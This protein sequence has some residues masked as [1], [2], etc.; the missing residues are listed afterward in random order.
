MEIFVLLGLFALV[1]SLMPWINHVRLLSARDEINGLRNKIKLL[2]KRVADSTASEVGIEPKTDSVPIKEDPVKPEA[3]KEKPP[4]KRKASVPLVSNNDWVKTAQESFEKNVATKLPVWIGAISLICA[5]FFLVKYSIELGWMKPEVRLSLGGLF[6]VFLIV[7]GHW[8]LKRPHIA[9]C[10]RIS[11]GLVGAGLVALYVTIYASLSLYNL[12]PPLFGFLAMATVTGFAVILSLRHGQPIAV[13][14]LLGGLLTP[15]LVGSDE[16]NAIAMFAYLFLLFTGMF[17]VLVRKGWWLLAVAAIIGVFAWSVFWFM[18][19]FSA[20]DAVILVVF[21]IAI[22]AVVLVV[23]GRRVA[24]N[25]IEK[26]QKLPIHS[27]NFAAIIGGVITIA[28]L[29]FEVSLTLFD[30]SMLG[31]LSLALMV[32]AYF[33]PHVYQK[34]IWAKLGASI[35]LYFIWVQ[36]APLADAITVLI[37]MA[38]VYVG[39]SYFL[40]RQVSDPRFWAT[41][42]TVTAIALYLVA[43]T[44]FDLP[45][46]FLESFSMF[47]GAV[48]LLLAGLAIYQ[49]A[50]IRQKYEADATIK[51]HLLA[52]YTLA[53]SA[54]ISI[55]LAIELPWGYV[56]LAIAAQTA[57][58]AMIYNRTGIDFLKQICIILTLVFAALNYEQLIMFLE[59]FSISVEEMGGSLKR[60]SY[61]VL[62]TPLIK[63]GI[64]SLLFV[65][66]FWVFSKHKEQNKALNHILFGASL[67]FIAMTF[68]YLF[69]YVSYGDYATALTTNASFIERGVLTVIAGVAGFGLLAG[70]KK[71][72]F[73][74]L[75][76]WAFG[77]LIM[78]GA[79][80]VYFDLLIHN[81]YWDDSQRVGAMPLLNGVTLTYGGAVLLSMWAVYSKDLTSNKIIYSVLGFVSLFVFSSLT[82]RQYFQGSELA[83]GNMI[84]AELYGYSVA[85]LLT[86][87]GLLAAG[88][89][90]ENKTLRMASLAF[91]LLAIAKAFLFDAAALDGL[92]RVFSFLGLGISL[93]GLSYFY[94]K[95]VFKK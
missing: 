77:L 24:E 64:P 60:V 12:I 6:G 10:Q 78:A 80:Y 65:L 32:L 57:V 58:T 38:A 79:R 52:I 94:S 16:P 14:G 44:T 83:D 29:S 63:L 66:S 61:H 76:P 11:Q 33:Q 39:A 28:W 26:E 81:P 45:P 13:F 82:V 49:V 72:D 20:S 92:Y 54:F 93:I 86:G 70:I 2:E 36:D 67:T 8:V 21:A 40:M 30:W 3:I 73:E 71:F 47:W 31:L 74:Y 23:T 88:I 91:M 68:Y 75:K 34:P 4:A 89:I 17:S 18:L 22:A 90:K 46:A 87:V 15:V 51:K 48:S 95:F 59:I 37:G 25:N 5:A 1:T 41:L 35:I 9:N 69:R 7:A 84:S 56:P 42:Q 50:D 55:G 62:D 43:Y 85:W 19:V 53:A 27:L